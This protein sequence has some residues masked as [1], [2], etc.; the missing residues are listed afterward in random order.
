MTQMNPFP[1]TRDLDYEGSQ[2]ITVAQFFNTVYAWMCV[3]LAVTAVVGWY[4]S[5]SSLINVFYASRGLY[6]M[7]AIGAMAIAWFVQGAIGR[8]SS[9][10]ATVL[11]LVYA[12]LIGALISAIYL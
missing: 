7:F 3:G 5:H 1:A 9:G 12:A 2:S 6:V 4:V 8:I 11:F 10:V